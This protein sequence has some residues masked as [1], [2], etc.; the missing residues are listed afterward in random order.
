MLHYSCVSSKIQT[1]G[2][3]TLLNTVDCQEKAQSILLYFQGEPIAFEYDKIGLIEVDGAQY[4]SDEEILNYMKYYAW[5]NC[6]NA[7]I[8]IEV[9]YKTKVENRYEEEKEYYDAKIYRGLA[10]KI[11]KETL[12]GKRYLETSDLGFVDFVNQDR[13]QNSRVSVAGF[14]IGLLIVV[15]AVIVGSDNEE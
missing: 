8:N 4:A 2:T 6:A 1:F 7:V 3:I 15:I 10:V 13:E 12:V 11:D 9:D 14:V 5:E